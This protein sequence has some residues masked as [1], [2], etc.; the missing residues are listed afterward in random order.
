MELNFSLM[1]ELEQGVM[2][3]GIVYSTALFPKKKNSD[4]CFQFSCLRT[5]LVGVGYVITTADTL[6]TAIALQ[7]AGDCVKKYQSHGL[8]LLK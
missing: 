5:S 4:L 2:P 7:K 1:W 8:L 3:D 6:E